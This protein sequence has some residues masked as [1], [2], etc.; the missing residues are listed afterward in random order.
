MEP[1]RDDRG[2]VFASDILYLL[3]QYGE[4]RRWDAFLMVRNE[5]GHEGPVF[6]GFRCIVPREV[7]DCHGVTRPVADHTADA[8]WREQTDGLRDALRGEFHH[9]TLL[10]D[11]LDFRRTPASG[12]DGIGIYDNFIPPTDY[13]RYAAGASAAGLVFSF[14]VNPG[15]DSIE[16]RVLPNCYARQAF[17]P[18]TD[19]LD[20]TTFSGR[21]RAAARS[22]ERIV[23]SFETTLSVQKDPG[24]T[25]RR[26]GFLLVYINSFN[27]WH[28]GHAFEPMKD[29][30]D[31]TARERALGYHNPERGDYR[32]P[33]SG[34]CWIG[35]DPLPHVGIHRS[36][37]SGGRQAPP[38]R[39]RKPRSELQTGCGA[40]C[41]SP[42]ERLWTAC[43]AVRGLHL[44]AA[45]EP[46]HSGR[47]RIV[48]RGP[49]D[50]VPLA[51]RVNGMPHA[52]TRGC[53]NPVDQIVERLW[54]SCGPLWSAMARLAPARRTTAG[55]RRPR[56]S[57]PAPPSA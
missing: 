2:R 36:R 56:R 43:A 8:T 11:S 31:L 38:A 4:K 20:W 41:G 13:A 7:T 50:G 40:A 34:R 3:R 32:R 39:A 30:A 29:A 55:C 57:A 35:R 14:N 42:V 18:P 28:E 46:G 10:A 5:D 24:L 54:I 19:G 25:N 15:F 6:K 47:C 22:A 37:T 53:G 33:R 44:I 1:Y 16:P 21:E 45:A 17:A 12:F 51:Q 48:L 9:L 27:E 26:K 52:Q 23:E 49:R